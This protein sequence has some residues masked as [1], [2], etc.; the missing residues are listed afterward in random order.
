MLYEIC[1]IFAEL[2]NAFMIDFKRRYITLTIGLCE[3]RPLVD[4][5]T[6]SVQQEEKKNAPFFVETDHILT[7]FL[8]Y[9]TANV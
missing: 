2:D 5:S 8:E 9:T 3:T 1:I 6:K 4:I 7:E